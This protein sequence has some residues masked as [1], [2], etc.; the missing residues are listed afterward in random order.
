MKLPSITLDCDG[1]AARIILDGKEVP[2]YALNFLTQ[3]N[4]QLLAALSSP[5]MDGQVVRI[6]QGAD[7]EIRLVKMGLAAHLV[8]KVRGR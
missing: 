3:R 4:I 1:S 8:K 7:R 2:L 6:E 5:G